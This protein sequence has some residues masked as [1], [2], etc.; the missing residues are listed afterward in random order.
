MPVIGK[1]DGIRGAAAAAIM[2]ATHI[3]L[4]HF[5]DDEVEIREISWGQIDQLHHFL[6]AQPVLRYLPTRAAL[7][8]KFSLGTR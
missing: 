5:V 8:R 2:L 6:V 7:E 1:R 3:S 4:I